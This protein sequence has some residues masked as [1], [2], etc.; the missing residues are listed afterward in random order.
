MLARKYE[1]KIAVDNISFSINEG[2]FIGF[3][4]PNGAGKTTTI[5]MLSGIIHPSSGDIRVM[6]FTPQKLQNTFKKRFAI[7]MGQKNQL[8][9]D[10][11]ALDSFHLLKEI[12]EIP[13]VDFK[14]ILNELTEIL[15]VK[16]LLN[17]PLRNL[18][19]GERMKMEITGSLLHNPKVLFLDEPTI[20]L[21]VSSRHRIREF[22]KYVNKEKKIT[23]ILTS[24]YLD[25]IEE[26]CNRI[27]AISKGKV[28]Y[29][30]SLNAFPSYALDYKHVSL[31]FDNKRAFDL[32]E[33]YGTFINKTETSAKLLINKNKLKDFGRE[34][35]STNIIFDINIEEV[36]LDDAF[37]NFFNNERI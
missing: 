9:W 10:I 7:I 16:H 19:L 35:F 15:D 1:K 12:Y 31:T 28:F 29:D 26:L 4:G 36:P 14:N 24:H 13:Y 27:I 25:D 34:V 32:L 17:I 20:G 5:K 37:V 21:D 23:I 30:G 22:L 3:I 18:S 6:G 2:D 11:P 33:R 8:W